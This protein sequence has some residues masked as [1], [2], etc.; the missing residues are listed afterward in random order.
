MSDSQPRAWPVPDAKKIGI[1]WLHGLGDVGRSWSSLQQQVSAGLHTIDEEWAQNASPEKQIKWRFP[2]APALAVRVNQGMEMPS[3]FNVSSMPLTERDGERDTQAPASSA[4]EQAVNTKMMEIDDSIRLVHDQIDSL[5][6]E[7]RVPLER[8][9]VCGFSQGAAIA[10]LGALRYRRC[11]RH[12]DGQAR[13]PQKLA[14]VAAFSGWLPATYWRERVVEHEFQGR[15]GG[16]TDADQP[17][18]DDAAGAGAGFVGGVLKRGSDKTPPLLVCQGQDDEL[19]P[20]SM[21]DALKAE[22]QTYV[23]L[24]QSDQME[25]MP[26]VRVREYERLGHAFCADELRELC[27]FIRDV[28]REWGKPD[29][30]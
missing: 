29:D 30:E 8:I 6:I 26:C 18:G 5:R 3:W 15:R 19:V 10:V 14:G 7:D 17:A 13:R 11:D 2:D 28:G 25:P 21:R 27:I 9:F 24:E 16:A 4:G 22:L 20:V 23:G 12:V 1:V